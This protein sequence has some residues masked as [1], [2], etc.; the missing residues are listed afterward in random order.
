[1]FLSGGELICWERVFGIS[2]SR[3]LVSRKGTG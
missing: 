3:E 2:N 1:M